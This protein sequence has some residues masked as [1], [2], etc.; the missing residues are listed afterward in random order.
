MLVRA[1]GVSQKDVATQLIAAALIDRHPGAVGSS[2]A[3]CAARTLLGRQPAAAERARIFAGYREFQTANTLDTCVQEFNTE[4][5]SV[6]KI[7]E[8]LERV[9]PSCVELDDMVE[10][11]VKDLR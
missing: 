6:S 3:L 2:D 8:A 1:L 11:L 5:P 4:K 9:S 7:R 10:T